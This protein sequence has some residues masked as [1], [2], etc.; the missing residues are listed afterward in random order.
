MFIIP[1]RGF[2]DDRKEP[3]G[4]FEQRPPG[5][6]VPEARLCEVAPSNSLESGGKVAVQHFQPPNLLVL[7]S[8]QSF[9]E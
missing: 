3:G 9:M 7:K 2:W 8:S 6:F 5:L 1:K 4:N